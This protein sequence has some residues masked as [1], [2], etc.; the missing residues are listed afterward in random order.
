MGTNFGSIKLPLLNLYVN[1][2]IFKNYSPIA[3]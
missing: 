1:Y 2:N 3:I